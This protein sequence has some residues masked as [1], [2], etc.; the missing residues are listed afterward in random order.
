MSTTFEWRDAGTRG[1]RDDAADV[2]ERRLSRRAATAERATAPGEPIPLRRPARE[3]RGGQSASRAVALR[4]RQRLDRARL[5]AAAIIGLSILGLVYLTQISHVARYGYLL[6]D[7]QRD[8][9]RLARENQL[10]EYELTAAHN[11]TQVDDLAEN[12]YGMLPIVQLPSGSVTS[13]ANV[14]GTPQARYITVQ[15]PAVAAPAPPSPP[16]QVG[17]IDRLLNQLV[18]IGVAG[19][20]R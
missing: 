10:L 11:L 18:G 6:S 19:A 8:Q 17:L 13:R 20:E 16:T 2:K 4:L 15:R 14:Q 9:D 7:L 3:R 12:S 5:V 1:R